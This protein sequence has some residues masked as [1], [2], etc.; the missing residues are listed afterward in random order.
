MSEIK[1]ITF[2]NFLLVITLI[3]CTS[4]DAENN[5]PVENLPVIQT[6]IVTSITANS[7]QSGGEIIDEG[8]SSL[9]NKGICWSTSENPTIDDNV[10]IATELSTSF[11][12][13]LNDLE[14]ET[15]YFVR[16]F[17]TNDTGI[18]YGNQIEFITDQEEVDPPCSPELNTIT[19]QGMTVDFSNNFSSGENYATFGNYGVYAVGIQGDL[20]IDFSHE[21]ETGIYTLVNDFSLN[22]TLNEA[23]I[24]AVLDQGFLNAFCTSAPSSG[25]LIYVDKLNEGNYSITFCDIEFSCLVGNNSYNF[26]TDGNISGE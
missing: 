22:Q 2:L 14:P 9:L 11:D 8:S 18:A 15:T 12:S 24:S 1:K 4:E 19:H 26:T 5:D 16:S 10:N 13:S 3:G 7:A 17:A 25:D 21:P 6:K 20:R 23:Y